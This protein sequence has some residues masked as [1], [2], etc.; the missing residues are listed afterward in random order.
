MRADEAFEQV[1]RLAEQGGSAGS[2]AEAMAGKVWAR[3]LQSCHADGGQTSSP[4]KELLAGLIDSRS[5]APDAPT[6]PRCT[7]RLWSSPATTFELARGLCAC[8]QGDTAAARTSA[9]RLSGLM[10]TVRDDL[11][12]HVLCAWLAAEIAR[13]EGSPDGASRAYEEM[14]EHAAAAEQEALA[15]F[16]R[17]LSA[18]HHA[19]T[20]QTERAFVELSAV[21]RQEGLLRDREVHRS[22]STISSLLRKTDELKILAFQDA[23]TGLANHRKLQLCLSKWSAVSRDSG[24]PLCAAVIDVNHF[25]QINDH[26]LHETG[27]RVLTN[28]RAIMRE[29]VRVCHL[30][31]RYGGDEFVVLFKGASL[32]AACEISDR[33]ERAVADYEWSTLKPGLAV[34]ISMGVVEAETDDAYGKV[35]DRAQRHQHVRSQACQ[36][37]KTDRV[38]RRAGTCRTLGRGRETT[39]RVCRVRRGIHPQCDRFTRERGKLASGRS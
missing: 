23:L 28:N 39:R 4:A 10:E 29:H 2:V 22:A 33:I 18:S 26:Y 34:S 11:W 31:A 7:P 16:A 25:K 36:G 14:R 9:D 35:A 19:A 17:K 27:D 20:G 1:G 32:P 21:L 12:Q 24:E 30:P 38:G 37:T 8:W 6:R 13:A 3:L 15:R 5:V